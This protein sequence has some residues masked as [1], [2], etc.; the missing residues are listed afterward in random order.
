MAEQ[1][2]TQEEFGTQFDADTQ[3]NAS[4][5]I[6]KLKK[7]NIKAVFGTGVGRISLIV[8]SCVFLFFMAFGLYQLSKKSAPP[9][10]SDA[11]STAVLNNHP[12]QGDHTVA[13]DEEARM[14]KETIGAQAEDAK[15][16]GTPFIAPP[17]LKLEEEEQKTGGSDLAPGAK[18]DQKSSAEADRQQD[19]GQ[20]NQ[21]LL[22][23]LDELAKARE[24]LSKDEILPQL[25]TILGRDKD[26][27]NTTNKIT[28]GYYALPDRTAPAAEVA[29][30][31]PATTQG[32]SG[33]TSVASNAGK[34]P[35]ISAGEGFYCQ[36]DFGINTDASGK[37]VVGTC[38]QGKMK[39]ARVIGKW[40]SSPDGAVDADVSVTFDRLAFAGKPTQAITAIA[41]NEETFNSGLADEVNDHTVKKFGGLFVASMLRGIGKAA[42]IV[43]GQTS[44]VTTGVQTV[45]TTSVD[46]I[47]ASRQAKIALGELGISASDVFQRRAETIKP[48][49]KVHPKKSFGLVFLAD[50]Y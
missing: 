22:R 39:N 2:T 42:S 38:F 28:T 21:S 5:K 19:Q 29:A 20:P 41:L 31:N 4:E 25:L 11:G 13:T 49:V 8:V 7:A 35:F 14:R 26:G 9:Q 10:G 37:D 3:K 47:S 40:T 12:A 15:K 24:R 1:D 43:T 23:Q 27:K 17:V 33:P 34:I 48:T 50:V 46:P 18:G 32:A 36:F 44:T 16:S 30:T 45:Q 6:N